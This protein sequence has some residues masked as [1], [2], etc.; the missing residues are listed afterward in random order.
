MRSTLF[1]LVPIAMLLAAPLPAQRLLDVD[2]VPTTVP[3]AAVKP[4]AT[5]GPAANGALAPR[6]PS[7][8]GRNNKGIWSTGGGLTDADCDRVVKTFVALVVRQLVANA[9]G[10]EITFE[11]LMTELCLRWVSET[12]YGSNSTPLAG[13]WHAAGAIKQG[14]WDKKNDWRFIIKRGWGI[15]GDHQL[16]LMHMVGLALGTRTL[17]HLRPERDRVQE[18]S[19]VGEGQFEWEMLAANHAAVGLASTRPYRQYVKTGKRTLR[20]TEIL[21]WSR[22]SEHDVVVFDLW[23]RPPITGGTTAGVWAIEYVAL[24]F[25]SIL[26]LQRHKLMVNFGALASWE[27]R[28]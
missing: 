28:Y 17:A 20:G 7:W 26:G 5:S 12:P 8:P 1:L 27:T 13:T 24:N 9:G 23:K 2:S 14:A 15:C 3:A 10:H 22:L 11:E 6:A 4:G 18:L 19:V 25:K 16:L 21:N